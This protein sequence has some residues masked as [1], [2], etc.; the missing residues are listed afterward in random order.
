ML[1]WGNTDFDVNL[2]IG[3]WA[4][5]RDGQYFFDIFDTDG[6]LGDNLHVNFAYA[7]VMQVLPRKYRLR[8]L[9]ACMARFLQL[10]LVDESGKPVKFRYIANDG[11]L[12]KNAINASLLDPQGSAERFDII[13]DFSKF[14]E[15]QRIRLINRMEHDD[16]RGPK[17][18]VSRGKAINETSDDPGVGGVMEF[19]IVGSVESVDVPGVYHY[20]HSSDRSKSGTKRQQ[21]E[22]IPIIEPVRTRHIEWKRLD[23]RD[24]DA[25]DPRTGMCLPDCDSPEGRKGGVPLGRSGQRRGLA[26]PQ[27][28]PDRRAHPAPGRD[29]ALDV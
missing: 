18:R 7:P 19:E 25:R 3:D 22:Q 5:D 14:S 24:Q 17:G 13:V 26:Q 2:M 10:Q 20:A 9:N 23:S 6:F 15:G 12:L 4:T 21:T 27:R 29:R 8:I 1:D 16:G 11:N 28:Q